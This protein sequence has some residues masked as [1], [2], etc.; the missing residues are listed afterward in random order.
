ML[1]SLFENSAARRWA[2]VAAW[3]AE[4]KG[5]AGLQLWLSGRLLLA[6]LP[7]LDVREAREVPDGQRPRVTKDGGAA[8]AS[9]IVATGTEIPEVRG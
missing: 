4:A 2:T 3:L 1:R 6:I 8:I 7:A 9:Y 5:V